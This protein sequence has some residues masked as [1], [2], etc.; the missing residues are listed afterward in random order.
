MKNSIYIFLLLFAVNVLA[1]TEQE[2]IEKVIN[3]ENNLKL[4]ISNPLN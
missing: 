1:L 2:F 3:Q 4:L